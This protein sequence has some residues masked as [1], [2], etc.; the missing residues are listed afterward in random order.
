M[1]NIYTHKGCRVYENGLPM[2]IV[3]SEQEAKKIAEDLNE[4]EGRYSLSFRE[5]GWR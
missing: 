4:R 2:M 5:G 1:K 3:S